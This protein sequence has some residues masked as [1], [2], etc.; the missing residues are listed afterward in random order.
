[1]TSVDFSKISIRDLAGLVNK[2][3]NEHEIRTVLVGGACVAIY[4]FNRYLSYDLD[5]VTFETSSKV[6]KALA[7]LG[8]L[9][10]GKYYARRDC[11]FFIEFVSPPVAVGDELIDKF[12]TLHS[13]FGQIELLTPTDC[14]KDRLASFFYWGDRQAL[15][16]AVMVCQEQNVDLDAIKRWAKSENHMDKLGEFLKSIPSNKT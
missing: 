15:E 5:F 11:P 1:M 14:V 8:F 4:S 13:P 12:K 7:E 9:P 2:K 6:E 3:F 16:Q 10:Q